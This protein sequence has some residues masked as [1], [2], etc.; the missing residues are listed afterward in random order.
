MP[1]TTPIDAVTAT[2]IDAVTATRTPAGVFRRRER[3]DGFGFT[4]E[5]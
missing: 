1:P 4:N 3:R 5:W 2:P